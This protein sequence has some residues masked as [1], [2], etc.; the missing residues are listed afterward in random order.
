V[1]QQQYIYH[2]DFGTGNVADTS[3][4]QKPNFNFTQP[5]NYTIKL[6]VMSSFGC[7]KEETKSIVAYQGLGGSIAGPSSACEGQ[8][9]QFTGATL[10]PGQPQWRWLFHDGTTSQQQKPPLKKYMLPGVY[11]VK[12][13]VNNN[14]CTDSLTHT[15]TVHAKPSGI[16]SIHQVNLCKGGSL[17]IKATGGSSYSWSPSTGLNSVTGSQVSAAPASNT[18]YIVQAVNAFGCSSSDSIKISVT[19]PIRLQ[20]APEA[21]VCKGNSLKLVASG[22][23][24]YKW[25]INTTTLSNPTIPNP[26]ANPAGNTLYTVTGTDAYNCFSD[27][28]SINVMVRPMPSVNAG[29]DA[30]IIVGTP[31]QLTTTA[32][33]DVSTWTWTPVQ[34]LSCSNCAMPEARPMQPMDYVVMVKN[35]FGCSASDT[36]SIKLLCSEGR[37]FIPNV[38]TPNNDGNNDRFTIKGEGIK[39]VHSLRIFNRWGETVFERSNFVLNDPNASWDGT[40]KGVPVSQGTYVYIAELSCNETNYTQKGVVTVLY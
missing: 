14:G 19:V 40:C 30:A 10:L 26:V 32:S 27:T 35:S 12:L 8:D 31:H 3:N 16:L 36:V 2:W 28:A 23:S 39:L 34:Y 25:I 9:V 15:L 21:S 6:R 18:T 11:V 17:D 5:G 4:V 33:S 29:A 22:A 7:I 20:L 1:P 13:L 24:S 37:I 38:F